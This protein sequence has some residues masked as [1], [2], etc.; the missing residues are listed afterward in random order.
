MIHDFTD[1]NGPD[2]R[3]GVGGVKCE[4]FLRDEMFL[5][6]AG[7]VTTKGN[8]IGRGAEMESV[9]ETGQM[10]VA[11]TGE[12]MG[13]SAPAAEGKG[14]WPGVKVGLIHHEITAG[15]DEAVRGETIFLWRLEVVREEPAADVRGAGAGIVEF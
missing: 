4:L 10:G 8:A 9:K 11:V 3:P 5:T 1:H 13:F 14:V 15:G 7:D 2:K 12:E 6:N